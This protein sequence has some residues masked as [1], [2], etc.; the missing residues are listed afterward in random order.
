MPDISP[1]KVSAI[2]SYQADSLAREISQIVFAKRK[3]DEENRG[4]GGKA[5]PRKYKGIVGKARQAAGWVAAPLKERVSKPG[6][7]HGIKS[8]RTDK[9]AMGAKGG[10]TRNPKVMGKKFHEI[11]MEMGKKNSK[12]QWVYKATVYTQV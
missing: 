4:K 5:T 11:S 12:G 8:N 2:S 6:H 10:A 3:R 9:L 7:R 1:D